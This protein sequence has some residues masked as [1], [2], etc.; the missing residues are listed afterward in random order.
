[1]CTLT[2]THRLAAVDESTAESTAGGTGSSYQLWFNRDELRTRGDEVPPAVETTPSGVRYIAPADSDAGG[3]WLAVNEAGVTVAL[4]N[5][6]RDSKGPP[7]ESWTSRGHLVRSMADVTGPDEAWTRLTPA[8]MAEY[9][10][11]IVVVVAPDAPTLIARWDGLD[12]AMD[13]IGER[14]LPVTS[15]SYEQD[16]VQRARRRLYRAIV[17]N[18]DPGPPSPELLAAYQS[19]VGE[20]G[21]DAFTP[22]MSRPDAAT[23]SQCHVAVDGS[24][25]RLSYAP[26]PP[27][28]TAHGEPLSIERR[29][30]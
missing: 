8:R 22:S 29:T 10:P 26:G 30:G 25:V 11:A 5:G 21:P 7:R 23:R 12:L 27:H 14:Q 2:W 6:Y 15:S 13:P 20:G 1:M 3:T 24:A 16:A 18:G 28:E 17:S 9:R 4:L 19:H